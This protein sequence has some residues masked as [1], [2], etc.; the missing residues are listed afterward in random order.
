[1]DFIPRQEISFLLN[2][3]LQVGALVDRP[4]FSQHNE[5]VFEQVLDLAATIARDAFAPHY[6]R[7]D[8]VEPKL[9]DGKV[10][11]IPEIQAA[12]ETYAEAGFCAA[13]FPETVG[14]MQLPFC[15][16]AAAFSHFMA[17][18]TPTAGYPMLTS[19]NA[20]L[21]AEFGSESQIE[22]WC[23]P[24]VE[25]RV[26]GTMCL[27]EPQAG[28]SLADIRTSAE[29]DGFDH[30]G[31]RYRIR[32]NKMWI[33]GGDQEMSENIVH[34]VLAKAADDT[35]AVLPGVKGI[36]L[37]AVPKFLP[38]GT[39]NDIAVAGLNHKMG[40]RGTVNCL[41][42]FG[43]T[44]GATGWRIGD[45]G[46]GLEIMFTMMNEARIMVGLGAAALA[47]RGYARS[48]DYAKERPQGRT[49]ANGKDPESAPIPIIAHPDVKRMLMLQKAYAEGGLA[50]TLY[51]ARLVDDAETASEP[52]DRET[53][54][55]LLGLLTPIVKSW[56]SEFGLAAND[57]AIQVHGG[58][59]YTRDYDVEQTYRD[60]RLNPIHEGTYG[61]Q[62]L[63]FLGRKVLRNGARD[64]ELLFDKMRAT[65][66]KARHDPDLGE[67]A[68]QLDAYVSEG[69]GAISD[70]LN[71]AAHPAALDNASVALS[72]FGHLVVAWLWLDQ[73]VAATALPD[74]KCC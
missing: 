37:F 40:Y 12:L 14:G 65:A 72:A 31:H 49:L 52:Q 20:R 17:A 27:S 39:R 7:S 53:A 62:G 42:N 47:F 33:S 71:H 5:D 66:A 41:L 2:D 3:W 55:R 44:G 29:Y 74:D 56:P 61:I 19:A 35:G 34:L 4:Y 28:S 8:A 24:Q 68:D 69:S 6:Q 10:E 26:F 60:N 59:G 67:L 38:D 48:L 45:V 25:G 50:L 15:V 54:E 36:S 1:M 46:Q 70:L 11:L 30:L 32:G 16:S 57:Q 21:L 63:D 73:A 23:K 58:Y 51:A 64:L 13:A 43:E 18:N 22:A 9:V